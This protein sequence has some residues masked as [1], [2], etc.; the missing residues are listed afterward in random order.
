MSP[1]EL[2]KFK[3]LQNQLKNTSCFSV[4]K[5]TET[6]TTLLLYRKGEHKNT[7]CGRRSSLDDF[8]RF[9][10]KCASPFKFVYIPEDL[11]NNPKPQKKYWWQD[12][13]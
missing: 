3:Q 12:D 4:N 8:I 10:E 6:S 1:E 2:L 11:A 9:A 13:D 5:S 7:Y